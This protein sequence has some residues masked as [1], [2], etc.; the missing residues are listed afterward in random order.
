MAAFARLI[1]RA[2]GM[3]AAGAC[4]SVMMTATTAQAATAIKC[5]SLL[6]MTGDKARK[7]VVVVVDGGRITAIGQ[8]VP[9]GA[10]VIDLSA[11]TCLPGLTDLH[12]HL[13]IR[14]DR[15]VADNFL[16]YSSAD[17][18]LMALKN[19]QIMLRH[20]FTTVRVPGDL[21]FEFANISLRNAINRGDVVGP[22]MLVAPHMLSE[23]GGHGDFNEIA[24]DGPEIP[25]TV[26]KS[27]VDNVR[28]AVRHEIKYGAD[29]IKISA[30]GGVMSEHDDPRVQGFTDEEIQAFAEEAHR[31]GKKITAHVH[32]D[33]AGY[34][35]AKAG[36][37]SIEH[38]TLLE[39]RTLQLMKKNNVAL[40]ST[41]YVVEW[42]IAQGVTGGIS[43]NNLAKAK[44]VSD[45]GR[46]TLKKAYDMGIRIGFGTDQIFPHEESPREFASLVRVGLTPIDA[47]RTATV[48]AAQILGLQSEIGTIEVGKAADI[49]AVPADPLA[50]ITVMEK[51]NFVMK[52]GQVIRSE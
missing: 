2:W 36:F 13:M 25:G 46:V 5:G 35:A 8:T 4:L 19:A 43:E 14:M 27:G 38:G 24:P 37:D 11:R 34:A 50:D 52:G 22:R 26:V 32:G 21:E 9:E 45:R 51:V 6:D 47:L 10:T 49:I 3:G 17:K 31:R 7:D 20:G 18:A 41:R 39:D 44:S 33:A 42:I 23:T 16:T 28:E 29:W 15:S 12:T 48:N 40:V 30:S 1:R